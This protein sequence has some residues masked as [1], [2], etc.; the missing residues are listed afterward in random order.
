MVRLDGVNTKQV[1]SNEPFDK[2]EYEK[3]ILEEVMPVIRNPKDS[4]TL[5]KPISNLNRS[6]EL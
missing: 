5:D 4:I 3:A 2:N 1:V 6:L